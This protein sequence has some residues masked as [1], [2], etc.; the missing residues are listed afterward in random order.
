MDGLQ[1]NLKKTWKI[2]KEIQWMKMLK[3][4]IPICRQQKVQNE[5]EKKKTGKRKYLKQ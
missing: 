3:I 1:R 4:K 2:E 5:G